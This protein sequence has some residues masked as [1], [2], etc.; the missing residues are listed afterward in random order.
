MGIQ[1]LH[2][3]GLAPGEVQTTPNAAL[4]TGGVSQNCGSHVGGPNMR[5]ILHWGLPWGHLFMQSTTS[6]MSW[7]CTPKMGST[8]LFTHKGRALM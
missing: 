3:L 7:Q 6:Q 8:V 1:G 4:N 5:M 2:S